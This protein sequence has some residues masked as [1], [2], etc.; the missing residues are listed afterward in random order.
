M[1]EPVETM[2]IHAQQN[3]EVADGLVPVHIEMEDN[4]VLN[5]FK[6]R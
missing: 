3:F 4:R 1:V 6:K 2:I 5:K